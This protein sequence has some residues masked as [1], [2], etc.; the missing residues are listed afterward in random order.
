[1]NTQRVFQEDRR[2]NINPGSVASENTSV[3]YWGVTFYSGD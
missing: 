3:T 2:A 1:M